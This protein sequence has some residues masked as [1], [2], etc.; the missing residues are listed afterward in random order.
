MER[1]PTRINVKREVRFICLPVFE[2]MAVMKDVTAGAGSLDG[3]GVYAACDF[4]RNEVVMQYDWQEL[5]SAEW[6]DLPDRE[7][8]S[9]HSFW[10][11]IQL[12]RSPAIYVNHSNHPNTEQDLQNRCDRALY[13]IKQGE[14]ITTDSEREIRNELDSLL[15]V[16]RNAIS[17]R[18]F[19]T[20]T[21]FMADK[22]ELVLNGISHKGA[23]AI[24]RGYRNFYSEMPPQA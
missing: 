10:G 11:R 9:A 5:T 14:K 7:K 16:H 15:E 21:T 20:A 8:Q 19:Q 12:F 17:R 4:Q 6:K 3:K 2:I 18:D 1:R 22:V 23:E 13:P 24:V